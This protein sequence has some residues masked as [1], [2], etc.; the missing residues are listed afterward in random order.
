MKEIKINLTKL[1][2]SCVRTMRG[3]SGAEKPCII[4][5]LDSGLVVEDKGC[6]L[7]L[8][9]FELKE[10]KGQTHFLKRKIHSSEALSYNDLPVIGGIK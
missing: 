5:P 3:Q 9:T 8:Q 7:L 2:G 10:A 4:I 6:Y 1:P